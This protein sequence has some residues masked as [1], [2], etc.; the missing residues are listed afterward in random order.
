MIA[1]Q[2]KNFGAGRVSCSKVEIILLK[3]R[4]PLERRK[5]PKQ[6]LLAQLQLLRNLLIASS[7]RC[8]KIIQQATAL[9]YHFKQAATGAVI[10]LVGLKM[11]RQIVDALG[12]QRDL[13]VSRTGVTVVDSKI[14]NELALNFGFHKFRN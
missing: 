6:R 13:N 12:K 8:V 4:M 5:T 2:T 3:K 11:F 7:I 14:L 10:F 1:I 9:S